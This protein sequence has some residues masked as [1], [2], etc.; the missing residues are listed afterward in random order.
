MQRRAQQGI[1]LRAGAGDCRGTKGQMDC[2]S[3]ILVWSMNSWKPSRAHEPPWL[4]AASLTCQRWP[5]HFVRNSPVSSSTTLRP[6]RGSIG[7]CSDRRG[8]LT[9]AVIRLVHSLKRYWY[10]TF[11]LARNTVGFLTAISMSTRMLDSDGLLA[12]HRMR[13]GIHPRILRSIRHCEDMGAAAAPV[14]RHQRMRLWSQFALGPRPAHCLH[15]SEPAIQLVPTSTYPGQ[16]LGADRRRERF[17]APATQ[18][19][20]QGSLNASAS[21]V[22]KRT[23]TPSK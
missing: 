8:S 3:R 2:V 7:R 11:F 16:E 21:I 22:S 14:E 5:T 6:C 9:V 10:V 17:T 23:P 15:P 20:G 13:L 1:P 4:F 19:P 12:N 18:M